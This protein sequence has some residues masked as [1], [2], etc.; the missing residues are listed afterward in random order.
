[1][2][3]S[4]LINFDLFCKRRGFSLEKFLSNNPNI[5]YDDFRTIMINANVSPPNKEAFSKVIKELMPEETQHIEQK[6]V[7]QKKKISNRKTSSKKTK[8]K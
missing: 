4:Y 7:Q 8:S 3:D 6:P 1:M 5:N 2:K